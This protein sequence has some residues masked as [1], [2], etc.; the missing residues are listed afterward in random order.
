M[1]RSRGTVLLCAAAI[2]LGAAA[3]AG[4]PAAAVTAA[5]AVA[6]GIYGVT[7]PLPGTQVRLWKRIDP[8]T[9]TGPVAHICPGGTGSD[10]PYLL[11][12]NLVATSSSTGGFSV[13]S[14]PAGVYALTVS[15]EQLG[16]DNWYFGR[17]LGG[18]PFITPRFTPGPVVPPGSECVSTQKLITVVSGSRVRVGIVT[19]AEGGVISGHVQPDAPDIDTTRLFINFDGGTLGSG[20]AQAAVDAPHDYLTPMVLPPGYYKPSVNAQDVL[21]TRSV[22]STGSNGGT[23]LK[24]VAR[25]VRLYDILGTDVTPSAAPRIIGTPVVGR[26]LAVSTPTWTPAA[27]TVVYNW[28]VLGGATQRC[29]IPGGF[30]VISKRAIVVPREMY[31]CRFLVW[32]YAKANH[33]WDYWHSAVSIVITSPPGA[34]RSFTAVRSHSRGVLRWSSP[35]FLGGRPVL[36]YQ[37]RLKV[38]GVWR[39]WVRTTTLS[40]ATSLLRAGVAYPVQVRAYTAAGIGVPASATVR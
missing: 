6:G 27:A 34:P 18:K 7:G 17:W 13:G 39:S 20:T 11:A 10:G 2:V 5:G 23:P 14:V 33:Y 4:S 3:A 35:S 19:L 32:T 25:G 36:G 21:G 31:G 12:T 37:W 15:P 1:R 8:A 30:P 9:A 16:A 29:G 38:A 40:A 22:S 26:T 24:V 28:E